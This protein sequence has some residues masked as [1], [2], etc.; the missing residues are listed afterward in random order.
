MAYSPIGQGAL[1]HSKELRAIGL[2]H[3]A[4]PAQ[5]ALAWVLSQSGV[6]AIPKA[7][8][9]VHQRENFTASGVHLGAQDLAELDRL[10]PPP[11]RKGPLAM[12]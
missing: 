11:A 7:V 6:V 4:T 3:A 2:R 10:F 5:V 9:E 12:L 1:A 8:D